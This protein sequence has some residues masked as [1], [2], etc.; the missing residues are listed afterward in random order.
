M[1]QIASVQDFD[2]F[3]SRHPRAVVKFYTT[4]CPDCRRIEGT[5]A[6]YAAANAHRAAFAEVNAEA[7]PDLAQRFDIRG[8][9]TFLV[10][11]RGQVV[12]RLH[13]RDAKTPQQVLDF[14]NEALS[15][16]AAP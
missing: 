7:V 8:V 3:L 12:A 14:L 15:Q 9:P 5:Y 11:D 13:S 16:P 6:E 2:Q 1:E 10:F 4:W